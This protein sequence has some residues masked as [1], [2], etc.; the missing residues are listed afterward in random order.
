M[1]LQDKCVKLGKG[2]S[3]F[4]VQRIASDVA[5]LLRF[6]GFGRL[7]VD[8]N[9]RPLRIGNIRKRF[10]YWRLIFAPETKRFV[11]GHLF[12][13]VDS[14]DSFSGECAPLMHHLD[15]GARRRAQPHKNEIPMRVFYF[16]QK[17]IQ[18]GITR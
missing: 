15:E 11:V 16:Q 18:K 2:L 6:N 12:L 8:A 7:L 1:P 17:Y 10:R 14:Q 13:A 4:L 3:G 9:L 5:V